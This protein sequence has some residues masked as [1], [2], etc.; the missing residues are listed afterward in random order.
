MA[1]SQPQEIRVADV[2]PVR[3][4]MAAAE[5]DLTHA[6]IARRL[7]EMTGRSVSRAKVT[8]VVGGKVAVQL[9]EVEAWARALGTSLAFLLGFTWDPRPDGNSESGGPTTR[10]HLTGRMAAAA[11]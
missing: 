6:A 5:H 9:D 1:S 7:S 8:A 3:I 2:I 10:V 11:A 4:R